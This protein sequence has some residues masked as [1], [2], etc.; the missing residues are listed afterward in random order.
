MKNNFSELEKKLGFSFNDKNILKQA[1]CHRSYLNENPNCGLENNERLEFL[2]DAVLELIVTEEL[3]KKY[4]YPEGKLTLIRAGL[5]NA[6][7]LAKIAQEL[8]FQ[9]YLLLSKG[10]EK[11]QGKGKQYI[12]A[13]TVE[14]LIGAIYLDQGIKKAHQFVKRFILSQLPQE[15]SE[16]FYKDFKT[17][18]QEKSQE[19][20]KITPIYKLLQEYG[21]D[22]DKKF[23]VGVYLNDQLIATGKGS[24]KQEAEE[25]AAQNAL[26]LK[27]WQDK[28]NNEF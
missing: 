2:G 12:L 18:L 26:I 20:L 25:D 9:N 27:G 21:P 16:D 19:F 6:K 5:V 13:N 23:L 22:H 8:D 15:I 17:K 4:N 24:S 3:F 28:N 1:F 10:E 11:N 14:S 7:N